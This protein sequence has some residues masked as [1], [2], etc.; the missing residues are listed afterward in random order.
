MPTWLATIL[1]NIK[2]IGSTVEGLF[3]VFEAAK[4]EVNSS[5]TPEQK[6]VS[7]LND[8][9][10]AAPAVMVAVTAATSVPAPASGPAAAG[11]GTTTPAP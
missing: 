1:A 10:T 4:T 3:Q 8:I 7:V 5:D 6:A 11:G 2:P 9:A